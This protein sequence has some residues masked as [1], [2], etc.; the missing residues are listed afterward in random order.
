[1]AV[2]SRALKSGSGYAGAMTT[3]TRSEAPQTPGAE[4]GE[5]RPARKKHL[6]LVQLPDES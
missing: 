3:S 2:V 5:A 4:P 1:M 6:L